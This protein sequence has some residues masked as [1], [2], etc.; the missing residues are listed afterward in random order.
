[1]SELK[2]TEGVKYD[3][4]KLRIAEMLEDFNEPLQEMCR[5]WQY[6]AHLYSKGNWKFVDNAK[7]RYTNALMRH[8]LSEK[9]NKYD[10]DSKLMHAAHVAWNALA[11]LYF[12]MQEPVTVEDKVMAEE[13]ANKNECDNNKRKLHFQNGASTTPAHWDAFKQHLMDKIAGVPYGTQL[14]L[15]L[16]FPEDNE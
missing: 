8:L 2:N 11:R 1:M 16:E 13:N 5:V 4:G 15:N 7:D 6:G 9:Y 12:I 14:T 3:K 10:Y